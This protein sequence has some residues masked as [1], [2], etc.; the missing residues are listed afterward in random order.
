MQ[1]SL[2]RYICLSFFLFFSYLQAAWTPPIDL[3]AAGQ[4]AINAQI[5]IDPEGNA[6][7]VWQRSNGS[8]TII[9]AATKPRLGSWASIPDDV[10]LPGEDATNPQI[11]IDAKGN[12]T[13]VWQRSNG[14]N[15]IIQA[16]T[17][18]FGG[19]WQTTPDDLSLTGEDAT[20]P[21]IAV[22][23]AGN[24]TAVWSRLDGSNFIIQASTKLF[25]GSWQTTPDDL[26]QTGEDAAFPQIAVDRA[27]NATA[28]W[29]RSNGSNLIIQASTKPFG[30]SWQLTPDDLSQTGQDANTA[31]I[32][33]DR[34]GNATAVWQRS[35]GSNLII[36]ASTKPFGG[37]WQLTP[38]D[39]SQTGQNAF[40]PQIAV[41]CA[42]NATAVWDTNLK[43][44]AST[45]PFGSSWQPTPDDVAQGLNAQFPQ[46]AVDSAGNATAV[47]EIS[48]GSN[49]IIQ[50]STKP[51]G[52][53]WQTTPDD[54][55]Q[56]GQ[57][58]DFPQVATDPTGDV[59]IAV[60][61]RFNGINQ[62]IQAAEKATPLAPSHFR[63]K[64]KRKHHG[65]HKW[66]LRSHWKPSQSPDV[67]SYRI[68]RGSTLVD[69]V[70]STAPLHYNDHLK[71]KGTAKKFKVSAFNSQNQE[72]KRKKIKIED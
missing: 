70:P 6:T 11:T 66:L 69:I 3:S 41:D 4:N 52:G 47:W 40:F 39:V 61:Q 58:A 55:S 8:N 21:Q 62:I 2:A 24:A 53:N 13:A 68:Y 25:G 71:R 29:Q 12:A 9:Q 23:R 19:S 44:Q 67:V 60:W 7:A 20:N 28:V 59:I 72:S 33:V 1:C 26:S 30:G 18:P 31:Q 63:G 64:L 49:S 27:G 57:N 45:K 34:A 42:G 48:N 15:T 43:I 10:S 22:D 46:I 35:N 50:A 17:K 65:E 37:S 16:S 5:A 32:A 51:F 14:S 56:P 38:D 36:Q 54:L